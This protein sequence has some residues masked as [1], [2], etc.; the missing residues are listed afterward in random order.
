MKSSMENRAAADA[1]S[2]AEQGTPS[3]DEFRIAPHPQV[4]Q[5]DEQD[6]NGRLV[7]GH[8]AQFAVLVQHHRLH[9]LITDGFLGLP[10]TAHSPRDD[11]TSRKHD[12]EF[13]VFKGF[14]S[15][16]RIGTLETWPTG[17]TR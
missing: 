6:E 12:M 16:I 17:R 9:S 5:D 15:E 1:V 4:D 11:E 7:P 14:T 13:I 2:L 3:G 10:L 8:G